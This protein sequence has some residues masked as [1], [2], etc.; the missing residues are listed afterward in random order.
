MMKLLFSSHATVFQLQNHFQGQISQRLQVGIG[1]YCLIISEKIFPDIK[2]KSPMAQL[3]T[4]SSCPI[5][6]YLEKKTQPLPRH[7][8]L[9]GGYKE[10]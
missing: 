6:H 2:S 7:S 9:S 4:I 5:T 10:Q 1:F 3:K 8:L